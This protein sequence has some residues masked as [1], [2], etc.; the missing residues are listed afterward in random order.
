MSETVQQI[1]FEGHYA[2]AIC[3][4]PGRS[5][6]LVGFDHRNLNRE[7]FAQITPSVTAQQ[8]GYSQLNV[9]VRYND[10]YLNDD[11]AELCKA[12]RRFTKPFVQVC[13]IGFSMGGFG[14]LL[15]SKALRLDHVVLVSPQRL[16]FPKKRPFAVDLAAE[17]AVFSPGIEPRFEGILGAMRGV[18]MY[19]PYVG[20]G[21][22]R[23][24]ARVVGQ[25]APRLRLLALPGG[26][27]PATQITAEAKT[28]RRFQEAV[29]DKDNALAR[30]KDL[31]RSSR[32]KAPR[33][34][35]LLENYALQRGQKQS[36]AE[37]FT[38]GFTTSLSG[39]NEITGR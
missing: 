23:A 20:R 15:L 28:Y 26:G 25:L 35:T 18:V 10:Y 13:G 21:R 30:L 6:L 3:H 27:H 2:R 4:N 17:A 22:D 37:S 8:R 5:H 34:Q 19:D 38:T 12:L 29:F 1:V 33:Y 31:H 36:A 32:L 7:G 11:L 9:Q 39:E 24:Y 14:A 16:D